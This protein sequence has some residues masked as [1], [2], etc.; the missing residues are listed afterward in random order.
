MTSA[1]IVPSLD[2]IIFDIEE[3]LLENNEVEV[4]LPPD[5]VDLMCGQI[6]RDSYAKT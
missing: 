3:G 6:D 1:I 2:N 5:T 4:A